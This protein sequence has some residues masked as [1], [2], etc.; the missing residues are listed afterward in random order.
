[1]GMQAVADALARLEK[2]WRRRPEA[3]PSADAP[4]QAHWCGPDTPLRMVCRHPNGREVLT[5]LPRELGGGGEQVSPGWLYR[6]G[7][8]SCAATSIALLA[9][10]EGV[11]L[12]GLRVQ[13]ESRSDGRGLLAMT[14]EQGDVV[15]PAPTDLRLAV[16]IGAQGA[17][18]EQLQALV[19]RALRRSPIPVAVQ[20]QGL[21]LQVRVA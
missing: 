4:A 7:L 13:A 10:A 20:G 15:S 14:D 5:D 11:E 17:T 21:A 19:A 8:A 12:T 1:M 6:A 9:A 2:I 3:G 18:P 16:E